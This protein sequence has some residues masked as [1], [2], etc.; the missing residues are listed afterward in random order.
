MRIL[1]FFSVIFF[2][3]APALAEKGVSLGAEFSEIMAV[4]N[5]MTPEQKAEVLVNAKKVQAELA[6]MSPAE[7]KEY[8]DRARQW[9]Q[10]NDFSNVDPTKLDTSRDLSLDD[11]DG[12]MRGG[13]QN[14]TSSP[15]A[16]G[17]PSKPVY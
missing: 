13:N 9:V 6:K 5:A 16:A 14:R 11:V 3:S 7:Q 15:T 12:Y 1:A 17:N 2:A 4:Y 10:S 8:Y